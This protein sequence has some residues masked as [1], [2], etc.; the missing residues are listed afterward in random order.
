[1]AKV[2]LNNVSK[3]YKSKTGQDVTALHEFN[4]EVQDR[5]L[6]VLAGPTDCGNST[7][8]QLIAGLEEVSQGE[9][10][11]GDRLLN[12]IPPKDRDLAMVFAE[13][14]LFAHLTVAEN[15]A[16]GLK[17]RKFA[18]AEIAKR[19][20]QA[21]NI[22]KIE[23]LLSLKPAGLNAGERQRVAI[24][25]AMVRQPKAFLFNAPL[26]LLD[27]STRAQLR[28]EIIDL[29]QRLQT[30]FI[31]ATCDPEEAMPLAD[32]IAVI[33]DGM[34][35]QIG[36]PAKL[37][38]EPANRFVAEYFGAPPMNVIRGKLRAGPAGVLFKEIGDGTIEL[39]LTPTLELQA[40]LQ[41]YAGQE[42]LLG[43]R[44]EDVA[45][46]PG[47]DGPRDAIFQGLVDRIEPMGADTLFQVATGAHTM[48][49]RSR[50]FVDHREAGRRFRFAVDLQKL[51]FFNPET[52]RRIG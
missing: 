26:A 33:K 14:A 42:V 6:I 43:I 20:N 17:L 32:R 1:M 15:L 29:H 23:P 31:Y 11:L 5:E 39:K 52:T 2:T 24:G 10:F 35:Q 28:A 48:V 50:G 12:A 37:Y 45:L 49:I 40:H 19:V 51:H 8:M 3:T 9:I 41:P 18:K 13:A 22:L 30:T 4:L 7:V 34:V 38:N 47:T 25:R 16:F 46:A 21:A 44:P 27:S 36:T